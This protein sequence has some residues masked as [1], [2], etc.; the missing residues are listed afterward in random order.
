MLRLNKSILLFITLLFTAEITNDQAAKLVIA[1]RDGGYGKS[2]QQ[3]IYDYQKMNPGVDIELLKL[4]YGSLYEKLVI[5]LREK[6]GSYGLV[7]LDDTWATEFM[8]NGLLD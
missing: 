2:L 4:P 5:S 3:T 7:M 8:G 6:T 1:G